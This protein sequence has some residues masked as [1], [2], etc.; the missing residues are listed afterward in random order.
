MNTVLTACPIEY[1][2]RAILLLGNAA[3]CSGGD[4]DEPV[5]HVGQIWDCS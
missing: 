3:R 5:Q 2:T 4:V 1:S